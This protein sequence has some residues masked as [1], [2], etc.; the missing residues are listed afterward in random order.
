MRGTD[1][2]FGSMFSAFQ[3]GAAPIESSHG[4]GGPAAPGGG[5]PDRHLR[6][7]VPALA[8]RLLSGRAP[9]GA[10]APLGR[11]Q[12][13]FLLPPAAVELAALVRRDAGRLRLRREGR[14]L[15]H[16]PQEAPRLR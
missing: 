2:A 9:A 1:G 7:A 10:R 16:A 8:R 12:R 6:L 14:P 13:V 15:P 5:R 4:T 11:D 3:R